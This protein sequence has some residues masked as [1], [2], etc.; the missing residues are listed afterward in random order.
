MARH[1]TA[2]GPTNARLHRVNT[3][4]TFGDAGTAEHPRRPHGN[5]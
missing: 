1:W 4:V 2:F 3:A 5:W